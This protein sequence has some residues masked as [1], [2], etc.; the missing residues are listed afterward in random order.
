MRRFEIN[1]YS[2]AYV[3]EGTG[4]PLVAVHGSLSD[5]RYWARQAVPLP[6]RVR[7]LILA[8]PGRRTG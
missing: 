7:F 1:G 8:E 6:E 2:M 5:Y 4:D 3:E